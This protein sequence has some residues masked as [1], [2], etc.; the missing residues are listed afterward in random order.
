MTY[1]PALTIC[2]SPKT[3]FSFNPAGISLL[4]HKP[5]E[6][7]FPQASVTQPDPLVQKLREGDEKTF[8]VLI[9]KYY[10]LMVRVALQ[11]VP[12]Q[13][14]ADEVVQETWLAFLESLQRFQGRCSIKTWLFRILTNRAKTRGVQEHR[15]VPLPDEMQTTDGVQNSE[16]HSETLNANQHHHDSR[17]ALPQTCEHNDPEKILLSKEMEI[18]IESAIQALPP[19]Q[20]QIIQLRDVE[21]W[22]SQEVRDLLNLSETNQRVLLHRAR[23]SVRDKLA[24]LFQAGD[25]APAKKRTRNES[26]APHTVGQNNIKHPKDFLQTG[27]PSRI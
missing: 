14:I 8:D 22:T 7:T 9:A 21:G 13:A 6:A 19:R 1:T 24:P 17:P 2:E 20:Q 23:V 3:I 15:Y 16:G 11:Y 27:A 12:T 25:N 26:H 4:R 10:S 18:H 5:K